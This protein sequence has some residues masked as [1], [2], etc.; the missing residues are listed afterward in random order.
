MSFEPSSSPSVAST[1]AFAPTFDDLGTPLADVTFVIVDLETTG[2]APADAG[3]TEIG[4]VKVRGGQRIGEF[5]T[6]VNPGQTIPPFV[7][8]LTGIT[9]ALVATAP[10]LSAVLPSFLDFARDTVL[11]AHNAPYDIG[12]LRGGCAA[13][14]IP[15]PNASVI[16]TARLARVALMRD[17]VR[18]CK[19]A[20]LAAYFHS[21]VTP[22][23][24]AL[25]DAR[26]TTDVLHGLLERVANLGVSTLEDL[27]AFTSRVSTAQRTKRH[28]ADGLPDSPGVYVF[29]DPQGV[30]LYVGKS[31]RIRTR[32][33]SY[34]TAA[35]QRRRMSEMVRIAERVVPIPCATDLEAHVREIRIIEA[36]QPRYNRRSRRAGTVSWLK[37]T[38]ESA[39]RLSIV[40]AVTDDRDEGG[41]YLGPFTSAAAAQAAAE[42]LLLQIP[43]RTCTPRLPRTPKAA[44][45]G[46]VLAELGR[47]A[48]PCRT[49]GDRDAY[50]RAVD[51]MRAAMDGN[52]APVVER[53]RQH[54]GRLALEERYEEAAM[55]RERLGHLA[56]ASLRTHRVG[57][58]A[59]EAELVAARPTPDQGWEIHLIR[60]GRLAGAT[61]VSAGV[62]PRPCVD[63]LVATGEVVQ[64]APWPQP[65]ALAEETLTILT[66]LEREGVRLVRSEAGLALPAQCG[67]QV[68]L[69][70]GEVRRALTKATGATDEAGHH[71]R[72][73]G[74]VEARLV[75][76]ISR[77]ASA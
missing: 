19:L 53:V 70:L 74:P 29:E 7:A 45:T 16:D 12:F 23:H 69:E 33:R 32:V 37:L 50:A 55:W 11:V 60:H 64:S 40:R 76:R 52:L 61:V 17:E 71:A 67:G 18:N 31:R 47:C 49:D 38:V 13:I 24:R 8:A 6:L 28:L 72:P 21:P 5:Q 4:A 51:Q 63:A 25:D 36:Q 56:T 41:R 46:C 39:P 58:L 3:I 73:L 10:R 59:R 57:A 65:A 68:A 9:D 44:A 66:W 20:T 14:E 42:A 75:S 30:P 43:L 22:T 27:Q 48:A 2:G 54:M 26:A 15:W 1:H 62:D 35:E 34:F 77:A